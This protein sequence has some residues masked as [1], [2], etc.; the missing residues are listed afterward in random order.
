VVEA[1]EYAMELS[2]YVHLNPVRAG[3]VERP[4]METIEEAVDSMLKIM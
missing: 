2:R 3:K 1:D 4:G